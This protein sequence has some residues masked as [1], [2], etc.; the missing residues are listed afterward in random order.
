MGASNSNTDSVMYLSSQAFA[1]KMYLNTTFSTL[2]LDSMECWI[3]VCG[4]YA[5][6]ILLDCFV[7]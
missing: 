3:K 1:L 5:D 4:F 7:L 2:I 6:F